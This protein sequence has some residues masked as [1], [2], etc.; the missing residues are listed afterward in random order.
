MAPVE[1]KVISVQNASN[2]EPEVVMYGSGLNSKQV[3]TRQTTSLRCTTG[4]SEADPVDVADPVPAGEEAADAQA[5]ARSKTENLEKQPVKRRFACKLPRCLLPKRKPRVS[6][7]EQKEE[8]TTVAETTTVEKET[9]TVAE[10]TTTVCEEPAV[11]K[12]PE[13]NCIDASVKADSSNVVSKDEDTVEKAA[14]AEPPT[15][16]TTADDAAPT[17]KGCRCLRKI[18]I[19]APSCLRICSRSKASRTSAVSPMPSSDDASADFSKATSVVPFN[20]DKPL[21]NVPIVA[22]M[23]VDGDVCGEDA[24]GGTPVG[25]TGGTIDKDGVVEDCN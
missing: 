21:V 13:Q 9:A 5:F 17:K 11:S 4:S 24:T 18:R 2:S 20:A 23:P 1:T 7:V 6:S 14:E 12:T 15:P 25:A 22:G 8:T 16:A 10:E 3:V 19:R